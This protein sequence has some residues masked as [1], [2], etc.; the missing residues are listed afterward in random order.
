MN[1]YSN[2]FAF[3]DPRLI[4]AAHAEAAAR[5]RRRGPPQQGEEANEVASFLLQLKHRNATEAQLAEIAAHED[6]ERRM[7]FQQAQI[8]AAVVQSQGYPSMGSLYGL[9]AGMDLRHSFLEHA[10]AQTTQTPSLL[11]EPVVS[12]ISWEV[13]LGDSKL[14]FMKDRD[15]VP[16]ALFV[17]MAQMK[18]CKLTQA[19]RVGCYKSRELGFVGMSCKHCGGQPGF[20]RYYPNSVRS[21]AQTT[22]SQT[23][24]KHIGSKCRFCPA[25]LRQAVLE[26]Q[27]QQA[28]KEGIAAG[29][30]RYGSRK[31]FFQRIWARLHGSKTDEFET[32]DDEDSKIGEAHSEGEDSSHE[33]EKVQPPSPIQKRKAEDTVPEDDIPET[34]RACV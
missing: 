1:S 25:H 22:T 16:D 5:N 7:L 13:L 24:L 20:G 14:V 27:R 28:A 4:A 12:E 8:R 23:I 19:D 34:K 21:L 10:A 32:D 29:R 11:E 6:A 31:I 15:L 17:A 30:P 33:A 18:A 26:L 2:P 9:P 3:A